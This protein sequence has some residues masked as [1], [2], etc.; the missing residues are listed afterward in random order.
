MAASTLEAAAQRLVALLSARGVTI[1]TAES[2]TGGMTGAAITS[3][4]GSSAVYRGGAI[5]YCNELKEA[6]LGVPRRI[7]QTCGAVS[8]E[9]A[10]AM[11]K[12]SLIHI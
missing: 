4:P 1:A 9:C 11:A 6:M 5:V 7:L 10:A 12:L 3:V 2:C 8:P